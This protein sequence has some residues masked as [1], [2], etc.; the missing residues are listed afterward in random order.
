MKK[1]RYQKVTNKSIV[2]VKGYVLNMDFGEVSQEIWDI[3]NTSIDAYILRKKIMQRK[4]IALILF[5]KIKKAID[6]ADSYE[7]IEEHLV[8]M[9]ILLDNRFLPVTRYQYNLFWL[10]VSQQALT[11]ETY[12]LLRHLIKYSEKQLPTFIDYL[13]Q[14]LEMSVKTYH[15]VATAIFC[16]EQC[17]RQAYRHL[18][19]IGWDDS[20][21]EYQK[22]LENHSPYKFYMLT[23]TK[24]Q[25]HLQLEFNR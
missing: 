10:I 16:I 2:E 6:N 8:Y 25:H 3:V 21:L 4:D 23:K 15:Q 14:K 22:G 5:H 18:S 12:C 19:Y 17:Y 11:P 20:L 7:E 9:N 1:Q 24:K 13:H